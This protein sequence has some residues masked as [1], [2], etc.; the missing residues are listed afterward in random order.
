M[1]ARYDVVYLSPHLDDAVLS[2][3]GQIY[4]RVREGKK[5]LVYSLM[6]AEQLPEPL[7]ANAARFLNLCGLG[8]EAGRI[9]REEDRRACALLGAEWKHDDLLEA[10]Y[11]RDEEELDLYPSHE[12][13]FGPL[14]AADAYLGD[15]LVERI[16]ALPEAGQVLAPLGAGRHVD[17][18]LVRRAAEKVFGS[19]LLYYE[20]YPYAG[21]WGAV[22][23]LIRP[24]KNWSSAVIPLDAAA[25][26]ARI[27]AIMAYASQWTVLFRSRRAFLRHNRLFLWRRGGERLWRC[28]G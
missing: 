21:R 8:A 19:R 27:E 16:S 2:C 23:R 20:D 9:R 14:Q 28:C 12:S 10:I 7:P 18:V 24:R 6:A 26:Q 15:I 5:V 17:H 4:R 1:Q 11:R 22:W 25:R 13:L 3:A